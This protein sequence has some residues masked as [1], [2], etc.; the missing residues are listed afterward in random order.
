MAYTASADGVSTGFKGYAGIFA[1]R[2]KYD[3]S[4]KVIQ[5]SRVAAKLFNIFSKNL[6]KMAVTELE[7]RIFEFTEEN[8]VIGIN[9]NPGTGNTFHLANA[10]A[11]MLQQ[12]DVLYAL[13]ASITSSPSPESLNVESIGAEDSGSS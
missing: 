13:K 1:Q 3:Y 5:K 12:G 11:Q 6:T 10:D 8:D 7:P 9:N 2:R 4:D